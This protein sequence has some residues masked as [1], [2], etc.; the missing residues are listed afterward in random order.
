MKRLTYDG[1]P[2]PPDTDT[3]V[4]FAPTIRAARLA[5]RMW[6]HTS[7]EMSPIDFRDQF[8]RRH[9]HFF[10]ETPRERWARRKVFHEAFEAALGRILIEEGKF[11]A[12]P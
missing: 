3:P 6:F 4:K 5:V 12:A 7:N 1:A 10:A 8:F 11:R 9:A 2:A